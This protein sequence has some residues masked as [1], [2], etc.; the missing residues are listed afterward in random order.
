M[1]EAEGDHL[2]I[3]ELRRKRICTNVL[4][5]SVHSSAAT[6]SVIL[7]ESVIPSRMISERFKIQN[8]LFG[9]I[10]RLA[11]IKILPLI[12]LRLPY[13]KEVY[14]SSLGAFYK[15]V[16]RQAC[17]VANG[18]SVACIINRTTIN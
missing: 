10:I 2:K 13:H 5:S 8:F 11:L 12:G 18:L 3:E 4:E 15:C 14:P 7:F 1:A 16:H 17:A 9:Y 6:D